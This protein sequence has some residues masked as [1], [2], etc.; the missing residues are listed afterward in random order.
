ILEI[1]QE[2][3]RKRCGD[4]VAGVDKILSQTPFEPPTRQTKRS[5]RP[6]FH[7][8]ST[9]AREDFIN[10]FSDFLAQYRV[11]SEAWLAGNLRAAGWFPEGC[12]PPAPPFIGPPPP[13]RPPLPPTRAITILDSGAVERGEIPIIEIPVRVDARARGQPP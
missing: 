8:A 5:P 12:Y 1:E 10:G 3:E 4:S 7:F 13:R 9:N 2:G 6:V 11:A